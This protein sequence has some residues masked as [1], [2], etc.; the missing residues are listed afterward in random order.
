MIQRRMIHAIINGMPV[1]VESGTSILEAAKLGA[2]EHSH[3]LQ[4]PR[5]QGH[6]G[7]RPVHRQGRRGTQN[8]ARL[9]HSAPGRHGYSHHDGE[10]TEIRKTTLELIISNHPNECLSCGRN[11]NCELQTRAAEFGIRGD[12]LQALCARL[13]TGQLERL[14]RHRFPQM[15]Q[16]RTV[17][18]GLP[19]SPECLGA[20]VPRTGYQHAHG[21]RRR[22]HPRGVPVYQVR[23]MWPPTARPAPSSK[24][25]KPPPSGPP[26]AIPRNTAPS[27]FAPSVR[28][29]LGEEFGY[30]PGTNLT[31]RNLRRGSATRLQGRLRHQLL[32]RSHHHGGS[33]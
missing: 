29:A 21:T 16:M 18:A 7:L 6:G 23:S 2:G 11:G 13:A 33:Q 25:T 19:G 14:D 26:S 22:H 28:V 1:E 20:L 32:R 10:L 17:R 30:P 5:S 27:R 31:K 4:T 12:L 8:A 9:C 3:S 15:H 24:R